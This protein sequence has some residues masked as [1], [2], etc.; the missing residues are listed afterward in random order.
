MVNSKA[1]RLIGVFMNLQDAEAA[2]RELQTSGFPM[3]QVSL[4][5]K[6]PESQRATRPP[7]HP[8]HLQEGTN[9]GAIAGGTVGGT[10]GLIAGLG[11][12]A[13]IPGIGPL[14]L[15]GELAVALSVTLG[16]GVLGATTGGLLGALIGSGIP[17]DHAKVYHDRLHR[18]EYLA[19]AEGMEADLRL[20]EQIFH[21]WHVQEL[22]GYGDGANL[23][24]SARRTV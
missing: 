10:L 20:A 18:G 6:H 9:L 1:G 2:V 13:A 19:I 8:T 14:M 15:L 4:I 16:G 17:E 11:V 5:G 12:I 21:R 24:P 3:K 23:V 22:R 7:A